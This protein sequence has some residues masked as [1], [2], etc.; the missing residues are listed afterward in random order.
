MKKKKEMVIIENIVEDSIEVKYEDESTTYNLQVSVDLLKMTIQYVD[1]LEVENFN[2]I[3][4]PML[5]D[6]ANKLKVD[7]KKFYATFYEGFKFKNRIKLL[8]HSKYL[9][10]WS[11][12]FQISKMNSR[13]SLF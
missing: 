3:I 5:I 2:F 1:F 9:F 8:K 4:N 7:E 13:T 10:I 6:V 12:R 11:G